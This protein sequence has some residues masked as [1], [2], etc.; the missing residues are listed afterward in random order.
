MLLSIG[1]R[2]AASED[3][4]TLLLECHGRIRSFLE[5]AR[6]AA[7]A[8]QA[9]A[10]EIAEACARVSRYFTEAFPLHVR[11]EEESVVPRLRG[12]S[13]EVDAAL[14]RMRREH[15]EH[16]PMIASLL[17]AVGDLA[18]TPGSAELRAALV[19]ILDALSPAIEAHLV[20]EET[21]IFPVLA[22]LPDAVRAQMVAELRA[23]RAPVSA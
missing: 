3:L 14:E 22:R 16:A 23:R 1:K 17:G 7:D 4:V 6:R 2:A 8:D 11:D 9:P 12:Q 15:G 18:G 10:A 19:V 13:V 21:V 5:I 20:Q